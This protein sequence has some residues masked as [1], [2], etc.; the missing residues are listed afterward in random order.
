LN[1]FPFLDYLV[2]PQWERMCLTLLE[3]DVPIW[4]GSQREFP[5]LRREGKGV[6]G[7]RNLGFV[8]A[9]LREDKKGA[10]IGI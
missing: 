10:A 7:G 5:I 1:P 9:G 8:W 6:I 3:V 2:G 4:S